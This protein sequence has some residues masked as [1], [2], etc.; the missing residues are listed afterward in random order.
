MLVS[1]DIGLYG[2]TAEGKSF[3]F[4]DDWTKLER[5][6]MV[7]DE[8]WLGYTVFTERSE[9]YMTAQKKRLRETPIAGRVSTLRWADV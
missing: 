4:H 6:H 8:P 1:N 9:D 5:A 7:L 3:E 2:I